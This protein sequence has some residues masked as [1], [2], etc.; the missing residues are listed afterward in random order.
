MPF[1]RPIIPA[2][3]LKALIG[4]FLLGSTAPAIGRTVQIYD[5]EIENIIR[6]YTKPVFSAAGIDPE[7]VRIHL[8]RS[9]VSNAFVARGQRLFVT[10]GLLRAAENPGQVIGVLAHETGHIAGGHLARLD[11][12]LRDASTPALLT[13]IVAAALGAL[14]G[15]AGAAIATIGAGTSVINRRLLSFS[16]A[17]EQAAD[18][19]AVFYLEQ[20]QQSAKGLLD[21]LEY[22]DDQQALIVSRESQQALNYDVTHPLTGDRIAYLRNHVEQ[23]EHSDKTSSAKLVAMHARMVAK[24]DGFMEPPARTLNKY[25]ASDTGLAAR[26]ARAIALYRKPDTEAALAAVSALITEHPDDPYFQELKGQILFEGG[27]VEEAVPYYQR[28]VD[29]MPEAPLLRIGLAHTQIE[30]NRP[31]LIKPALAHLKVAMRDDDTMV[32]A[33]RLAATAYG[34][35]GKL[36]DSALASAEYAFRTGHREDA[37]RM[38]QRAKRLLKEGS[39]SRIRAEDLLTSLKRTKPH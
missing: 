10:T 31:D 5:T 8:V 17:Q 1:A 4:V 7:A 2:L 12:M 20:S 34:R 38:A 24:L 27:R 11:S 32:L 33:W 39:P 15:N 36:G 18:R 35:S 26:Y 22:L 6:L 13:T 29:R 14:S 3:F 37:I 25:K 23:S 21:F 19:A 28:A 9:D 16:R 30:L